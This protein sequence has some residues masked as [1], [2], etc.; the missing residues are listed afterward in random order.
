MLHVTVINASAFPK[1]ASTAELSQLELN[2]SH[3]AN[4]TSEPSQE[5]PLSKIVSRDCLAECS[6]RHVC[7]RLITSKVSGHTFHL[8]TVANHE[9]PSTT[10]HTAANISLSPDQVFVNEASEE[11]LEDAGDGSEKKDSYAPECVDGNQAATPHTGLREFWQKI[12]G[13]SKNNKASKSSKQ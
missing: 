7:K 5:V 2:V 6:P 10:F 13:N 3:F 9:E 11:C 4:K 8:T 12:T 1:A